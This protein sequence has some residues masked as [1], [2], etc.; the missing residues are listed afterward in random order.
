MENIRKW[1]EDSFFLNMMLS[2]IP[3]LGLLIIL[4][5]ASA[6]LKEKLIVGLG[7]FIGLAGSLLFYV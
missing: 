2:L 5:S 6:P 3:L 4:I 1:Y 7:A